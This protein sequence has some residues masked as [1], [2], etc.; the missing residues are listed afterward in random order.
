MNLPNDIS[1]EITQR[2]WEFGDFVLAL[3]ISKAFVEF[4]GGEFLR[5]VRKLS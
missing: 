5:K 1:G 4:H 2:V 3:V